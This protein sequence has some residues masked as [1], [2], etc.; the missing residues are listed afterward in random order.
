M[1]NP[2][3]SDIIA[4]SVHVPSGGD[5]VGR[6]PKPM[7]RD[8]P[9]D[10]LI[11]AIQQQAHEWLEKHPKHK[12]YPYVSPD[13]MGCDIHVITE[14]RNHSDNRWVVDGPDWQSVYKAEGVDHPEFHQHMWDFRNY[15]SF[16]CLAETPRRKDIKPLMP[17]RGWPEDW[18][19]LVKE[20]EIR[21]PLLRWDSSDERVE[22]VRSYDLHTP[23]WYTLQE[24]MT[25]NYDAFCC[26]RDVLY[27]EG[28]SQEAI[29]EARKVTYR[30]ILQLSVL[31]DIERLRK[32]AEQQEL[33]VEDVRVVFC[34]DS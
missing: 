31:P 18:L 28:E 4:S 34:F 33:D 22:W 26:N 24:L 11:D 6:N 1:D 8:G 3:F 15:D 10:A 16:A 25:F 20:D 12:H 14:R 7:K 32:W 13:I 29:R 30:D 2:N 27:F 17:K 19:V 9:I 5:D 21:N 23:S